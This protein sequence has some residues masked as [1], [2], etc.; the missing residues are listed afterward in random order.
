MII[1]RYIINCSP[2][3]WDN[4]TFYNPKLTKFPKS[5]F[6]FLSYQNFVT[7]FVR[8]ERVALFKIYFIMVCTCIKLIFCLFLSYWWI[9]K[10]LYTKDNLR[11]QPD[12]ACRNELSLHFHEVTLIKYN[13]DMFSGVKLTTSLQGA[14]NLGSKQ[15]ITD[16]IIIKDTIKRRLLPRLVVRVCCDSG[17]AGV[18]GWAG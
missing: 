3:L 4:N 16:I 1:I 10:P 6:Q 15:I 5:P 13:F 12:L 7:D 14:S 18:S 8:I 11:Y 9:L 17:L 2:L